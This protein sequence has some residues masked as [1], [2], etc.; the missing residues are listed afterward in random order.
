MIDI[1]IPMTQFA[2]GST[3]MIDKIVKELDIAKNGLNSI[4]KLI[5]HHNGPSIILMELES[6][7]AKMDNVYKKDQSK[8]ETTDVH[9]ARSSGE[10]MD[11]N[12]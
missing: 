7:L 1:P 9:P 8:K 3:V 5:E 12:V 10:K 2:V 6:I 4:K 11:S